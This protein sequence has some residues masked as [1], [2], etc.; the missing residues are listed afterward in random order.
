MA[1]L[2]GNHVPVG[3]DDHEMVIMCWKDQQGQVVELRIAFDLRRRT[4]RF[5]HPEPSD[6]R[7]TAA[8]TRRVAS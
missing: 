1:K 6:T 2:H 4:S 7:E 3:D 5:A 8:R